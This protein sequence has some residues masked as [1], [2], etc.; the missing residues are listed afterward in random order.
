MRFI[1]TVLLAA[2]TAVSLAAQTSPT[3]PPG[4]IAF[5]APN[6]VHSM[7]PTNT[8]YSSIQIT[9][10][11]ISALSNTTIPNAIDLPAG[12]AIYPGFVDSHSH[13]ISLLTAQSLDASGNP[14]WIS[15]ANV[16]VMLLPDCATPAPGSITCFT[17]VKTQGTVNNLLKNAKPN[18]AGWILGWNYEPSRLGCKGAYGFQCPNFENQTKKPVL[19]QLDDLQSQYPVLV[20]S[21]SGHIVYVNTLA[22]NS[23]NICDVSANAGANCY[24]PVINAEVEKKLART[25]QLDE[26]IAVYALGYVE[27]LLANDYAGGP[28]A[29]GDKTCD[30]RLLDFFGKQIRS[31]LN[32]YSQL[33]YTTVQEGAAAEDLIR[34]YMATAQALAS[35]PKPA[36]LP[37]TMAF[38]EYD[39]T[40]AAN[41]GTSVANAQAMSTALASG[42]F[43]MFV[44]GM[45]AFADGSN[46]GYTGDMSSPVQYMNLNPPFTDGNIFPQPYNGLPDY[47]SLDLR[48]A[49][50]AAHTPPAGTGFPLW[51]HTN[52]NTAQTNVLGVLETNKEEG[53]RDVVVHFTMPSQAQVSNVPRERI[54]VTFLTNDF[55]Y[56]YQPLCEQLLGPAAT[57][58]MY[59]TAWAQDS[60]LHY[61]LHSDA[62]VTP[63]SPM[64]G[65][66][67]ASTRS[68]QK[69]NWLPPLSENCAAAVKT[70][71]KISRMQAMRAYTSEAAWLYNRENSIG[72]LQQNF[73]GDLVVLS[74]DPLAGADL[75]QIYVLYTVH[76]G[77]VVYPASGQPFAYVP[78]WP[79]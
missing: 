19:R 67:V 42:G 66:W 76:N 1:R 53:L 75:S 74:A 30:A 78:V 63:P 64:F 73:N 62:S 26:D 23:L 37:V 57:A 50:R 24:E 52:G 34:I 51:V 41:F 60:K 36:W 48:T 38:L 15:L 11:K 69:Q 39:G 77:N 43:D 28:C 7:D 68:Y 58:N 45:K 70:N 6:A 79:K 8:I 3:H 47:G 33:G 14:Y 31:S 22:L 46:Q 72:S 61:T 44:A 4:S 21:E 55:Y 27:N 10:G 2:L 16:N 5:N 29:K 56:Y 12:A 17:P 20:T 59:P 49:V 32:L 40:T 35:L 71:Q 18:A 13:A 65:V 25:G 9:N 54:G